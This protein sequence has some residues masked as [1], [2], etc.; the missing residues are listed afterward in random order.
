[1]V[2]GIGAY[3]VATFGTALV[4]VIL[5]LDRI[6]VLR[7]IRAQAETAGPTQRSKADPPTGAP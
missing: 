3:V 1:V 4:L 6:P 5:E 2:V 7:R